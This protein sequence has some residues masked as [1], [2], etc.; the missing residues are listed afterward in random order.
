MLIAVAY[1]QHRIR[2]N[3]MSA[4]AEI[5]RELL[6]VKPHELITDQIWVVESD[7]SDESN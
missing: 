7:W 2:A 1:L 3:V 5:F 4:N 6:T